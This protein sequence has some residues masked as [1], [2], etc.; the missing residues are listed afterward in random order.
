MLGVPKSADEKE[1][2]SA[3]RKLARKYHPDVNPNDKAAEGKFKEISEAYEVLSDPEKKKLY[4]KFGSNW[5][6]AQHFTGGGQPQG[7]GAHFEA[8]YGAPGGFESIFEQFFANMGHEQGQP[9][10]RATPSRDV[11]KVVELSLEEIDSGTKRTL[12]YQS[13]DAC[14]SCDG[15]GVVTRNTAQKCPACKG[16]GRVKTVFGMSQPCQ[17]CGGSGELRVETCPTC[18]GA[19]TVATTKTVEVKI[20]AGI[21]EGKKLRVPGKGVVGTGGRAGDLY[22]VIKEKPHAKFR[23]AGENLEVDVDVPFT[24]AALGGEIKV[25]TLRSTVSMK[26]P[27]GTQSGQMFRLASQGIAKLGGTRG[28]LM[29]RIKITVPKSPTQEQRKLLEQLANLEKSKV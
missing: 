26:I 21:S 22:V 18:K 12:T 7:E 29:A 27:E 19:G 20:P 15:L 1:I 16:A 28:N 23:R 8:T 24:V 4:D 6:H 13:P 2:K 25:P 17:A 9:G 3:Y 5:E 11:E 10:V 14:K